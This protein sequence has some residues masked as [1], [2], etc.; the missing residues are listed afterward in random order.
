MDR[1]TRLASNAPLTIALESGGGQRAYG[2]SLASFPLTEKFQIT[3]SIS[4]A[5]GCG[6]VSPSG[7]QLYSQGA[8]VTYY[9]SA[10]SGFVIESVT[11]DGVNVGTNTTYAFTNISASH[12]IQVKF[13][14]ASP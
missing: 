3:S 4:G 8:N 9:I 6:G 14:A 5:C 11:V 7:S 1:G 13:V 10:D 12:T 2:F